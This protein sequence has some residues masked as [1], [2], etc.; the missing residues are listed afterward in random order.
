MC[1]APCKEPVS[2]HDWMTN[3]R[4]FLIQKKCQRPHQAPWVR[5][6]AANFILATNL[7]QCAVS[8]LCSFPNMTVETQSNRRD[9]AK[10]CIACKASVAAIF[11]KIIIRSNFPIILPPSPPQR[12]THKNRKNTSH[13]DR[14]GP[15]VESCW[16]MARRPCG[17]NSSPNC[18]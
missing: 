2:K 10:R 13:H 7:Y 12:Y 4:D 1:F 5:A 14:V 8:K 17:I 15:T 18:T 9:K 11:N 6:P 16:L 3:A